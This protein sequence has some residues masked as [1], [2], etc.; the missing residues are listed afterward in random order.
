M[1]IDINIYLISVVIV[2]LI[3]IVLGM[4]RILSLEE[5]IT[6]ILSIIKNEEDDIDRKVSVSGKNKMNR[7]K[8]QKKKK[9][10]SKIKKK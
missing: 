3:G 9:I 7:T 4:R 10:L 6:Y 2:M 8:M 5:K 1:G